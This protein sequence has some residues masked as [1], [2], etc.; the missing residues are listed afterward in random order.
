[1]E[2]YWLLGQYGAELVDHDGTGSVEG[3][4]GKYLVVLGQYNLVL[5]GIK[6][7]WVII[8]FLCL[9]ILKKGADLDGC[10]HS[11][12]TTMNIR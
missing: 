11:G 3:G 7:Y 12:T 5:F 10:Y 6:W 9:Y 2:Q 4:T 8:G 1:M